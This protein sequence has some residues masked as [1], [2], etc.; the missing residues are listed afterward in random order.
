MDGWRPQDT[1]EWMGSTSQRLDQLDRRVPARGVWS[2]VVVA[3]STGLGVT[4]IA[5]DGTSYGP[6][7]RARG[8]IPIPG[9]RVWLVPDGTGSFAVGGAHSDWVP[10]PAAVPGTYITY[11]NHMLTDAKWG[12]PR[13]GL[14]N[15]IVEMSGMIWLQ[16]TAAATVLFTLPE[17]YRPDTYMTFGANNG[18]VGRAITVRPDGTVSI[19]AGFTSTWVNL[20][21]IIFP[22]AGR[23]TWT[24]I[25][26]QGTVGSTHTFQNSW[27]DFVAGGGNYGPARFW[28]DEYGVMWFAGMVKSGTATLNLAIFG[29]DVT[30]SH[31]QFAATTANDVFSHVGFGLAAH[32][33]T[34][35]FRGGSNAWISLAG[36]TALTDAASTVGTW[37]YF[38]SEFDVLGGG[39]AQFG[40]TTQYNKIARWT[41]PDGLAFLSGLANTGTPSSTV[42][43][44]VLPEQMRDDQQGNRAFLAVSNSLLG[45]AQVHGRLDPTQSPGILTIP[46]G[47]TTWFSFESLKWIPG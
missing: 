7:P 24:L 28:I 37:E 12:G 11:A 4:V 1:K 38:G 47:N 23:A 40:P 31:E 2:D 3:S 33:T 9:D 45:R 41:R 8:Y 35:N 26:P 32:P 43:V 25:D 10:L 21:S 19:G 44:M 27:V 18:D 14:R 30:I 46:T 29:I 36:V 5:P 6:Y 34:L 42:P 16:A 13:V 20:D 17:G 39:W 15:G 22:Q